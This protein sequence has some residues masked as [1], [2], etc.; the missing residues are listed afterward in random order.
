MADADLAI[1][2]VVDYLQTAVRETPKEVKVA[3]DRLFI[4]PA[5]VRALLTEKNMAKRA[6]DSYPSEDN[7]LAYAPYGERYRL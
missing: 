3:S 6:N 7:R 2:S 4:L 1:D 5:D